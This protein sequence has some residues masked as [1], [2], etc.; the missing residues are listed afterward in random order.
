MGLFKR[1]S[2]T[3]K[4]VYLPGEHSF[5]AAATSIVNE[6][7]DAARDQDMRKL[8]QAYRLDKAKRA[9]VAAA[10][11]AL[12]RATQAVRSACW[13]EPDGDQPQSG[14]GIYR[15]RRRT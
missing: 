4:F 14:D 5:R 3:P 11:Y 10:L 13:P 7:L 15:S 8:G 12:Q 9:K 1:K 6:T 2:E